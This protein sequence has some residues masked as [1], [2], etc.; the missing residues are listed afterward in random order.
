MT[1]V[2]LPE[3]RRHGYSDAIAAG[4]VASGGTLGILIPPSIILVIYAIAS[5]QSVPE[6]FAAALVPGILLTLLH[7]VAIQVI[8]RYDLAAVPPVAQTDT[9]SRGDSLRALRGLW[10]LALLFVVVVGGIYGGWF[11]PT[12][13]AAFG[14]GLTILLGFACRTLTGKGLL[15]SLGETIRTTGLLFFIVLGAYV[16]AAFMVETRLPITL[17]NWIEAAG[18]PPLLVI[19]FF[20]AVY[21]VLGCFL[22]SI[23]MI[24][25]TVPVFLPIAEQ[26]GFSAIWFGIFIVIVAEIG[27]IT[28]PVGLNLFVMRAQA[29]DLP[30]TDI[31]RGIIPFVGV[32]LIAVFL[33]IAVPT[34]ATWLPDLLY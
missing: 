13:A 30:L 7:M 9:R 22:D 2:C 11:T 19:F 24:L 27:L 33:L 14:A 25:I 5:Q 28:P 32:Q 20:L 4:L 21:L 1:K 8:A 29:R 31:Y 10:K 26:A 6:L 17:G 12:E 15:A 16:F 18:W 3:M 34:L 23:S